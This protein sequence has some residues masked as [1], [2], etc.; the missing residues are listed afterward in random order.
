[1]GSNPPSQQKRLEVTLS[2]ATEDQAQELHAAWLE[3]LSGKRARLTTAAQD[4]DEIMERA[5]NALQTISKAI[6]EHPGTGQSGLVLMRQAVYR[7]A[8]VRLPT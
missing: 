5:R 2:V 6:H 8:V 3:I 1:M 7:W 4:L